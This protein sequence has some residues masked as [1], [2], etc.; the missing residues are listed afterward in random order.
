MCLATYKQVDKMS[1]KNAVMTDGSLVRIDGLV[2]IKSGD[3]LEVYADMAISK[4][5]KAE[6]K[7]V[8]KTRKGIS[9]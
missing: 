5:T 9:Q 2:G 1:G 8:N 7:S 6:N 3:F 4:R